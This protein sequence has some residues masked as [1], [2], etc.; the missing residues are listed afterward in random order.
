MNAL[1]RHR[2]TPRTLHEAYPESSAWAGWCFETPRARLMRRAGRAVR[3]VGR[4]AAAGFAGGFL[5]AWITNGWY[6]LAEWVAR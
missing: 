5:Y 1:D 6:G 2:A 4:C 3:A